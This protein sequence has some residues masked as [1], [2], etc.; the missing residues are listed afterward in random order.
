[1]YAVPDQANVENCF[2]ERIGHIFKFV[3]F[4]LKIHI[5][6]FFGMVKRSKNIG[7][8]QMLKLGGGCPQ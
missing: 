6:V 2:I 4:T 7:P 1:M 5:S 8:S 3:E